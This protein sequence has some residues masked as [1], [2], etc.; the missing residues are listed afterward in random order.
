LI[1]VD[2]ARTYKTKRT[3]SLTYTTPS[4]FSAR[5]C[6]LLNRLVIDESRRVGAGRRCG[7]EVINAPTNVVV[8]PAP[9][10]VEDIIVVGNVTTNNIINEQREL[11]RN[12]DRRSVVNAIVLTSWSCMNHVMKGNG[13]SKLL[14]LFNTGTVDVTA[15]SKLYTLSPYH[16]CLVDRSS[17]S[18][19]EQHQ[20]SL[21][22]FCFGR[23]EYRYK[24]CSLECGNHWLL[25]IDWHTLAVNDFPLVRQLVK[26]NDGILLERQPSKKNGGVFGCL[27]IYC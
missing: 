5:R 15:D 3:R 21:L 16:Y 1:S 19:E 2:I 24:L 26:M 20:A 17:W 8:L 22:T 27:R 4:T 14:Y 9:D 13:N 18:I 7:G 23:N 12:D 6:G 10:T 11:R 25:P